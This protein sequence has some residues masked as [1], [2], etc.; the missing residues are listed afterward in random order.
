MVRIQTVEQ[1]FL[2]QSAM[3]K[4]FP[5]DI[6][7]ELDVSE[8]TGEVPSITFVD[9]KGLLLEGKPSN[10]IVV[11]GNARSTCPLSKVFTAASFEFLDEINGIKG[12]KAW[13]LKYEKEAPNTESLLEQ[14]KSWGWKVTEAEADA[15]DWTDGDPTA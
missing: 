13:T 12:I 8:F 2:L 15:R 14:L 10:A 4:I 7:G 9:M 3:R 6:Q 11:H 5:D 1:A